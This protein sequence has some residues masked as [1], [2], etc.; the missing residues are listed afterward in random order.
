MRSRGSLADC[1]QERHERIRLEFARRHDPRR[2]SQR[3]PT[4]KARFAPRTIA[5]SRFRQASAPAYLP[6]SIGH[7]RHLVVAPNGVVY[8]NTWSG[9]NYGNVTPPPA[10][11]SWHCRTPPAPARRTSIDRFGETVQSGGAG[12]TGIGIYEGALYAESRR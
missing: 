5:A 1:Q 6:M 3:P 7:A 4:A 12:G 10:D 8:V 11:F 9:R 2:R